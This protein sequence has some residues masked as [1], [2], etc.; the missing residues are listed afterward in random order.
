MTFW[1]S[2]WGTCPLRGYS[3]S[4]DRASTDVHRDGYVR[5]AVVGSVE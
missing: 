5:A 3:M 1:I 2:R 4:V